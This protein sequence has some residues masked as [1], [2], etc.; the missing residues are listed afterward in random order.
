MALESANDWP[1]AQGLRP[2]TAALNPSTFVRD[3]VPALNHPREPRARMERAQRGNQ[4][5]RQSR[6]SPPPSSANH[7]SW[8]TDHRLQGWPAS[9]EGNVGRGCSPPESKHRKRA[10][11]W[12][13][14]DPTLQVDP[15]RQPLRAKRLAS[16]LEGGADCNPQPNTRA[17]GATPWPGPPAQTIPEPVPRSAQRRG[18]LGNRGACCAISFQGNPQAMPRFLARDQTR[19]PPAAREISRQGRAPTRYLPRCVC[20]R[21]RCGAGRPAN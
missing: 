15:I 20:S 11:A 9:E 6:P 17:G 3:G 13:H 1:P 18:G 7:G 16:A 5:A 19:G 10:A 8:Q 12:P 4:G 14:H 2:S 21:H